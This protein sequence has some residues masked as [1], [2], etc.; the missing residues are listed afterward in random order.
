MGW[1]L[2][3]ELYRLD[4][5]AGELLEDVV[6]CLDQDSDLKSVADSPAA[7][8]HALLSACPERSRPRISRA[9]ANWLPPQLLPSDPT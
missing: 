4:P 7:A 9:F 3:A 1:L 5:K 6:A 8:I 2:A